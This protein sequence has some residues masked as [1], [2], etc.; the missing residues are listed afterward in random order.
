MLVVLAVTL[1]VWIALPLTL[2]FVHYKELAPILD[3]EFLGS[4]V[5]GWVMLAAIVGFLVWVGMGAQGDTCHLTADGL[6]C[7]K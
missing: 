3:R 6:D 4:P 1:L 5:Y 2:A 7:G